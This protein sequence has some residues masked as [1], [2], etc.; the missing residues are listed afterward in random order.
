MDPWAFLVIGYVFTIAVEIPIL[1]LGLSPRHPYPRRLFAGFWLNA[2]SYPIVVIV[3]PEFW[4]ITDEAQ[5]VTYLWV[6]E[7]FA[8]VAECALFWLAFGSREERGRW[9]M[10]RDML[11]IVIANLASFGLGEYLRSVEWFREGEINLLKKI[12][13]FFSGR[14]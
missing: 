8:P 7:I 5:R 3:L 1:L 13:E 2:C 9:S 11:T 10:G 14:D 12:D 4:D 6:A